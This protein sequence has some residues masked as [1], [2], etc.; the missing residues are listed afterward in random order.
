MVM[1]LKQTHINETER[2]AQKKPIHKWSVNLWQR[3]QEYTY[4]VERTDSSI[5]GVM[6][7]GQSCAKE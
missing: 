6:K 2:K 3:N 4:N 5:N 1:V 7:P